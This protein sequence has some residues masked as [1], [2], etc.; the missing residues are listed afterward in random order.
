MENKNESSTEIQEG[1]GN[2]L[3]LNFVRAPKKNHDAMEQIGKP[4]AQWFKK[5]GVRT[6][7]YHLSS[8]SSTTTSEQEVLEGVESIAKTLSIKDDEEIWV[9][10][11]FYRD[12]AHAQEIMAMM[13][14]MQDESI[15]ALVKEFD[16]LVTQGSS[17]IMGGF[18][19]LKV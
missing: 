14:T 15:G 4:F 7:I 16:G 8:N 12:Q 3:G 9:M 6:E 10:L 13:M 11:Q 17:L 19:R 18:S 5:H 1:T 2:Y